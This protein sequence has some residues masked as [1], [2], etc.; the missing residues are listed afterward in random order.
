M[1][2]PDSEPRRHDELNNKRKDPSPPPPSPP[3]KRKRPGNR[4]PTSQIQQAQRR[5]QERVRN[6]VQEQS[7]G[8]SVSQFVTQHYNAV[9]ERGREWRRTESNIK[10][11]RSYNNWVKSVLIKKCSPKQSGSKILDLGCGKGGDLPKWQHQHPDLYVGLDPADVS[12]AQAQSRYVDMTRRSRGRIFKAE[13]G[14]K[15]CFGTSLSDVPIVQKVGFDKEMDARWGGGGFDVVTMMFCMHY[16]FENEDMARQM[17]KNVSGALRKGGRMIGVIPNSDVITEK[18]E[19]YHRKMHPEEAKATAEAGGAQSLDSDD[20]WDPEKSLDTKDEA[21]AANGESSSATAEPIK[22]PNPAEKSPRPEDPSLEWGNSIYKVKFPG[23]TPSDGVF[24]PP[25]GW[26]YFYF[27]EEAVDSVPEYVVP[28]EAFRAL[29]EDYN[30]E[31]EYRKTFGEVWE[32]ERDDPEFGQLC[33]RMGVK[34]RNGNL[35]VG[36]EEMEAAGFYHAFCFYKV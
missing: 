3:R 11:L 16:A 28:W 36:K 13:F 14:V 10:G 29:A 31:L 21:P 25:F 4:I 27:L 23:K 26:K 32:E 17:L 1:A 34:D 5:E 15:D 2:P 30:L 35:K 24:R 12:I 19:E 9:P 6:A 7:A 20:D 22:S 8:A 33:E 18:V